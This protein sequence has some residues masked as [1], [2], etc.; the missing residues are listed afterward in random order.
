MN[1]DD[2]SEIDI[3]R[4]PIYPSYV[5]ETRVSTNTLGNFIDGIE[6]DY[7][8]FISGEIVTLKLG[9]GA[10][11]NKTTFSD[12]Q[13]FNSYTLYYDSGLD[14]IRALSWGYSDGTCP[15]EFSFEG[16]DDEDED[17]PES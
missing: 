16:D 10:K 17:E 15:I 12:D 7:E 8:S 11:G 1:M 14:R 4:D 6:I 9:K 2:C 3:S 13:P 5:T